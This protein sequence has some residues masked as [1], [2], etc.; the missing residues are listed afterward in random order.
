[1]LGLP[2]AGETI[3]GAL[4]GAM[5][6]APQHTVHPNKERHVDTL[7]TLPQRL[8]RNH[9]VEHATIHLLSRRYPTQRLIARTTPGGFMLWG[10]LS[11]EVVA[12]AVLEAL[13]RLQH[14]ESE[15]ALHP[16]CGSNLV[17]G[18]VLAGMATWLATRGRRRSAL[19][20]ATSA[21]L[22]ATLALFVA[23]PLGMLLQERVTTTPDVPGVQLR[24]VLS[25]RMGRAMAH[26]VALT[27]R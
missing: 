19:E 13:H 14:G 23:Q 22:A 26:R 5:Y 12:E 16:N 27:H 18:G 9:A 24:Q 3:L 1:M 8:R 15:L 20:Q 6:N 2:V 10:D 21:M 11:T 25:G 7:V 17:A 4:A